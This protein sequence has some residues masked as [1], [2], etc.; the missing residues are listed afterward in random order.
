MNKRTLAIGLIILVVG[1]ASL[2]GGAIGALGSITINRTFTQPQSGEY[3]SAEIVLNTTSDIVVS[4][5]ASS[6]GIVR[7]QDLSQVNSA[8]IGTYAIPYNSTAGTSEVYKSLTGDYYYVAF[9]SS[10]PGSTIV[11]TPLRSGTARY[12]LLVLV[13]IVLIIAGVVVTAIGAIRKSAPPLQGPT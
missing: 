12:G 9:S 2:V 8:D 3:V 5:P 13:G 1:I 11:A 4:S 7:A 6:G 10:Q